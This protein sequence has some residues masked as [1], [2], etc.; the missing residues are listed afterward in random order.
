MIL[1]GR[2]VSKAVRERLKQEVQVIKSKRGF[3]PGLAV[4]LV[5]Q[6]PASQV[7]VRNKEK[8][9]ESLGIYSVRVDM[10]ASSSEESVLK[11]IRAFND[12]PKIDGILV[13]MPVPA[14]IRSEKVLETISPD[15]DADGLTTFNM[16]LLW[17]GKKKVVSCTPLGV[18]RILEHYNIPIA[19]KN[20]VVIGRSQIV[21][22]PMAH[23]L[24]EANATV[25]V[26]HSKTENMQ[27]HLRRADIVVVAAGKKRFLGKDDFKQGSVVIDVGIHGSGSGGSVC[28]DVRFEEL[29]GWV[30]AATPVPGGVGPMTITTLLENTVNL[31]KLRK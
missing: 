29:E 9:C 6:D 17:V 15:K 25:T 31:A 28:G 24:S 14:Q 19:G 26:C 23:L 21:G 3:P 2:E 5:G 13:Q 18:M 16:G 12:D 8:A 22:K 7:Y 30:S 11:Q 10:D 4:I 20:V 1:D 27:D